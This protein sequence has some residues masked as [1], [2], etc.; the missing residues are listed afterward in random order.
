M[1]R[2]IE[3]QQKLPGNELHDRHA[4]DHDAD[5]IDRTEAHGLQDAV[6]AARAVVERHDGHHAVVQAK[7]RHKDE[8][9]ELE[10]DAKNGGGRLADLAEG[11]QD[12]VDAIGHERADGAHDRG[13]NADVENAAA[14]LSLHTEAT[15][16]KAQFLVFAYVQNDRHNAADDLAKDRGDRRTGHA[17]GGNAECGNAEDQQR[18]AENVGDRAGALRD[19][20]EHRPAGRLKQTLKN[21]LCEQTHGENAADRQVVLA[22]G[23]DLRIVGLT[24]E[25]HI[26][27]KK[28]GQNE[29]QAAD[30]FDEDTLQ[31][32]ALRMFLVALA[33]TFGQ[34]RV[35][36]DADADT[37]GDHQVLNG[38]GDGD[39]GERGLTDAGNE[40]AVNDVVKRLHQ[41]G[42]HHRQR[43]ADQQLADGHR[44]H[45]VLC[46]F[47]TH[48]PI[49]FKN[50][51]IVI[52]YPCVR[53]N[54][55]REKRKP[56]TA[57]KFWLTSGEKHAIILQHFERSAFCQC[58]SVG[59]AADS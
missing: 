6:G 44:T 16:S 10:V 52:L 11:E 49:P 33:K 13:G 54:S 39:G 7:D 46:L 30:Q 51:H 31:G 23:D 34:K 27:R 53:V 2:G 59:R 15:H 58:G 20:R 1:L 12:L 5:S 40:N 26:H 38:E 36:A 3:Q 18:V 25:K 35:D 50:A 21:K 22:E 32:N 28:S 37:E 19:H 55:Y 9:L 56:P 43:H 14:D 42:C 17:H 41:H 29:D 47:C 48:D 8:A 45:L 4:D 24:A 57:V